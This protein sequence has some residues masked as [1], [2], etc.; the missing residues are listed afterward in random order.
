MAYTLLV[1]EWKPSS[2]QDVGDLPH[3]V[4]GDYFQMRAGQAAAAKPFDWFR[5]G[6]RGIATI[7]HWFRVGPDGPEPLARCGFAADPADTYRR[8][9]VPPLC[10]RCDA[11]ASGRPLSVGTIGDLDDEMR[12][13]G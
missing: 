7:A 5:T 4:V 3:P 13:A 10:Q 6:A 11:I 2:W 12:G 8:E 1:L 9:D